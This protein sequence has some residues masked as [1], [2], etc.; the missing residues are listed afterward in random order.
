L[1]NVQVFTNPDATDLRPTPTLA[2]AI[3]PDL[4]KALRGWREGQKDWVAP[5]NEDD[6]ILTTAIDAARER[7]EL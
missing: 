5:G 4:A 7:G 6:E 3:P 2:P 1:T